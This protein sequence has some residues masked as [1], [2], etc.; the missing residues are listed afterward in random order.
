MCV[1]FGMTCFVTVH[2]VNNVRVMLTFYFNPILKLADSQ[3]LLSDGILNV[4]LPCCSIACRQAWRFKVR[5]I[6]AVSESLAT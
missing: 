1:A 4:K 6:Y 3:F 5:K 2:A